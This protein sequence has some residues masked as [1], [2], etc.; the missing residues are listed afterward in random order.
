MLR[1]LL[2]NRF[3][4]EGLIFVTAPLLLPDYCHWPDFAGFYQGDDTVSMLLFEF[5][6]DGFDDALIGGEIG[7][8]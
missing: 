1:F 6:A 4:N 8:D 3:Q 5:E 7:A 2:E